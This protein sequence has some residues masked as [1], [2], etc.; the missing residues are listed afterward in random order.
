MPD[1]RFLPL[2]VYHKRFLI[3][4]GIGLYLF[5]LGSRRQLD[6]DLDARGTE[7]LNNLNRLA[8][9]QQEHAR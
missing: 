8:R 6:F 1:T 2:V 7:V 9:T 5:Q 4:W 3:W